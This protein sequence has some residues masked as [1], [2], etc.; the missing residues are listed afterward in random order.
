MWMTEPL[1]AI[2]NVCA[3]KFRKVDDQF[4]GI[5]TLYGVGYRYSES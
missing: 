3:K 4:D 2:L 1:I 5:E